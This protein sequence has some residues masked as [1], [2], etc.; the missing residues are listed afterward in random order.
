MLNIFTK[1]C[2]LFEN[3]KKFEYCNEDANERKF[4]IHLKNIN[5]NLRKYSKLSQ[6]TVFSSKILKNFSIL[7]CVTNERKFY[8]HFGNIY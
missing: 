6:N 8:I 2:I 4:Y 5:C 1:H 7:I 3:T